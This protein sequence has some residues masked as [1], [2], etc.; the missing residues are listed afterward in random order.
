MPKVELPRTTV[1]APA[2]LSIST[3]VT[4]CCPAGS[5]VVGAFGGDLVDIVDRAKADGLGIHDIVDEVLA[6]L[7]GFA[8]IG[9]NLVDAEILVVEGV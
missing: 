4:S 8:L 3:A 6:V 2:K 9:R 7:P 1:E 5:A